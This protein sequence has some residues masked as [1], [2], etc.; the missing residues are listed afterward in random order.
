MAIMNTSKVRPGAVLSCPDSNRHFQEEIVTM[1]LMSL[2]QK[3]CVYFGKLSRDQGVAR[4]TR[5]YFQRVR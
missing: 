5:L 1:I 4:I 2:L 3:Y